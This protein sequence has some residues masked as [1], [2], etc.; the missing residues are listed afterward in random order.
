MDGAK[1]VSTPLKS[2]MILT[3]EDEPDSSDPTPYRKIMRGLQYL[4][5][6]QPDISFAVNK[7]SQF[8]HSPTE[9]HRQA[10]KWILQY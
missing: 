4:A 6:T 10:L 3:Y 2:S 7:L 9:T 5:F 1:N 8:M